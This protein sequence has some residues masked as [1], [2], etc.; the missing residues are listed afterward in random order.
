MEVKFDEKTMTIAGKTL[1]VSM[2][3][4]SLP[5]GTIVTQVP[6]S[7][8]NLVIKQVTNNSLRTGID[9]R[10]CYQSVAEEIPA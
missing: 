9:Y 6:G 7:K 3:G 10:F 8:K 5:I 2:A 4:R 1:T